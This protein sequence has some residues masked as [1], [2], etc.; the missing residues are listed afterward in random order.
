MKVVVADPI[1][2]PENLHYMDLPTPEPGPGEVLVK[3]EAIGVNFIDVYFRTGLYKAP[4][5][6]VTLGQEGAGTISAV[7]PGV[8]D[9][10]PGQRVAYTMTRGSYAEYALVPVRFLVELPEAVSFED[11]A[12][13]ML[14]GMTAHYLTHSTFALKPGHTCLIHAAAGGAG[15]LLVQ[16]AKIAGATVIGTVSTQAKADIVK[17]H[18]ADH[19][20]RYTEQDFVAE[21]KQFTDGKGVD[22]VYDSVGK[23]TFFQSLDCLRPRGLMASF[24]QSSGAVGN[25]D[26]LL[27]SQKG[28]LFLTRPSLGNYISDPAELK[29]RSTD[30]FEWIAAGRLRVSIHKVYKLADAAQAHRDLE[31]RLTSGKLLLKP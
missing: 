23:T 4:E 18:G 1:G 6:P 25:V 8:M 9:W 26:P 12:A 2:G 3:L 29:W 5:T 14:Q 17:E 15:L 27:L 21:T 13:V 31:A 16:L 7:G 11:G 28:S 10:R 22:V 19:V 24:G 30:L 20:I